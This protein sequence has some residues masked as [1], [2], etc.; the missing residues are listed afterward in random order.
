MK[1]ISKICRTG[2]TSGRVKTLLRIKVYTAKQWVRVL[3]ARPSYE[4]YR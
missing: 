1:I 4:S 3:A 2:I